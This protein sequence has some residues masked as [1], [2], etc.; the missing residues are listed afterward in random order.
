MITFYRAVEFVLQCE[1][2]VSDNPTDPGG[3]TKY[4]ISKRSHP[5]LDIMALTRQDAIDIYRKDYWDICKCDELPD[6]VALLVFDQAVNQGTHVARKDL[7]KAVKVTQDGVIG[8]K[9]I[10]AV[11]MMDYQDV[12]EELVTIRLCRYSDIVFRDPKMKIFL[13]GWTK[14]TIKCMRLAL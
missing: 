8:P 12:I 11:R 1:G 4:G 9:T 10:S 5:K 13:A 6:G 3:L 2:E 7:Q 14:R